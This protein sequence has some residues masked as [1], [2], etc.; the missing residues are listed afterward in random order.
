MLVVKPDVVRK[1]L[2]IP[3]NLNIAIG[4]AIGYPD[5]ENKINNLHTERD[6]VTATVRFGE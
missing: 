5:P 6:E 4:I 2:A 3:K 1:E